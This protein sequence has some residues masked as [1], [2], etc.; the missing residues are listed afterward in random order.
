MRD[1]LRVVPFAQE[2]DRLRR[3]L[4]RAD[5]HV[6]ERLGAILFEQLL[7]DQIDVRDLAGLLLQV[8]IILDVDPVWDH[9]LG[10][11]ARLIDVCRVDGDRYFCP[12]H[13]YSSMGAGRGPLKFYMKSH[14]PAAHLR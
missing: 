12:I 10:D 5:V 4:L 14:A 11:I 7:I 8:G 2:C 3:V 6:H 1:P 9:H 13:F